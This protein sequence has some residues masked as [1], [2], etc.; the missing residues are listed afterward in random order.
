MS[1]T[2]VTGVPGSG[3]TLYTVAVLLT[4]LLK[5]TVEV[6]GE[7][8]PRKI[9]TNIKNLVLDHTLIDA[10]NLNNWHEWVKAGD[11]VCF[12]EVQEVWRPRSMGTKVPLCIEKLE[13]HRHLGID[14]ILL[15]QHQC[16]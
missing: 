3:K 5:S 9:F 13:T 15:T 4:E 1:L 12:D 10:T 7:A 16:C 6:N 14:M 11:V 8:V 2:L